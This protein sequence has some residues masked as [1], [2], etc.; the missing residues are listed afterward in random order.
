M[1][2]TII[3]TFFLIAVCIQ[4]GYVI[5]FFSRIK[6]LRKPIVSALENDRK[7]VSVL[8]CARNE[9]DNL[10]RNLPQILSQ[11]YI[12]KNGEPAY[13]VIVVNDRSDDHSLDVLKALTTQ[14]AH[15]RY[16]HISSSEKAIWKGKRDA[17]ARGMELVQND[18]IVFTDADCVPAGKDWL[19]YITRPF[20]EG[21]E[22]VCGYGAYKQEKGMLNAMV[23]C[24]TMHTFLQYSTYA[25][26]GFPYMA[27][28]RNMACTKTVWMRAQQSDRWNKVI[29]GDDDM[30]IQACATKDNVAIVAIPES[31][32]YSDAPRN[33]QAWF[34]QKKRHMSTGK[35]YKPVSRILLSMYAMSHACFWIFLI[36]LLTHAKYFYVAVVFG[37]LRWLLYGNIW[38][39][40]VNVT[41]E[42][43]LQFCFWVFDPLW[44]LYNFVLSP[45]II[46]K[47]KQHWK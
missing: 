37:V 1:V 28:G 21:K 22:I 2:S 29:S 35:F 47:N 31:H 42:K 9:A 7:P 10:L 24:E 23:R 27:V 14:Y 15:L 17:L 30:L 5:C 43:G 26:A 45:Y 25:L 33:W 41:Q 39:Q 19:T 20:A 40:L 32:T 46:F 8:I 16:I 4:F 34:R 12:G 38:K 11:R 18:W 3:L 36:P 13:E 6:A 44:L